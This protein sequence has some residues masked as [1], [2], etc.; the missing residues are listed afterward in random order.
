MS[1]LHLDRVYLA[2]GRERRKTVAHF[3]ALPRQAWQHADID[4]R[5][6]KFAAA[7]LTLSNRAREKVVA[8]QKP[9]VEGG[10]ILLVD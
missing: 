3:Q 4:G 8:L 5:R 9:E 10:L 6:E 2:E 1:R 7:C